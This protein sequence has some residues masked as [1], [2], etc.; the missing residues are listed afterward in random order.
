MYSFC[1]LKKETLF[2][3]LE[4]SSHSKIGEVGV[5]DALT[6]LPQGPHFA[7]ILTFAA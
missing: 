1:D 2:S 5:Q 7:F 3:V 6:A 4:P